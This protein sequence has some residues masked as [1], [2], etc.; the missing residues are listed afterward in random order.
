MVMV[1]RRCVSRECA[2]TEEAS[3]KCAP[4]PA[5][6]LVL[7]AEPSSS[8]R[9]NAEVAAIWHSDGGLAVSREWIDIWTQA[10]ASP[11][12]A[13][14]VTAA[15]IAPPNCNSRIQ[16]LGRR[17]S[18]CARASVDL[19]RMRRCCEAGRKLCDQAVH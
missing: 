19:L 4:P 2:A 14:L 12:T 5:R 9:R 8:G 10:A 11:R 15:T 17:C 18:N 6:D 3:Q 7:A 16:S 13:K 1:V